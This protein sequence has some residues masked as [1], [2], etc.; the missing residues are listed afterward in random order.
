MK[1]FN[2]SKIVTCAKVTLCATLSTCANLTPT[3]FRSFIKRIN[4]HLDLVDIII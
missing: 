2:P 1:K 3:C 4:S